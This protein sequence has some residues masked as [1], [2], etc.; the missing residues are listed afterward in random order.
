MLSQFFFSALCLASIALWLKIFINWFSERKPSLQPRLRIQSPIGLVD[1]G[2]MF[3]C[4]LASQVLA[5]GI[6]T[7]VMF[8]PD[9]PPTELTGEQEVRLMITAACSQLIWTFVGLWIIGL[10]YGHAPRIFGWQPEYVRADLKIGVLAFILV[11]PVIMII[12][13]LLTQLVDYSH[14]TLSLVEDDPTIFVIAVAWFMAVLVAPITEELFFRGILQA[15]LQRQDVHFLQFGAE[16]MLGG[17]THQPKQVISDHPG[18]SRLRWMPIILSAFVFAG[19]H[20]GQGPAP[21]PLFVFG[22]AL[23]YVYRQTGSI[24]GCIVMHMLLNGISMFL[25][26]LEVLH[27]SG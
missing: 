18:Q 4:W 12:Q 2:I 10:R 14:S 3:A 19:V 6:V 25:F 11:A 13:L 27:Q 23:G 21:I 15:W 5:A 7:L 16:Q 8:F 24:L 26:T 17:W 22:V 20:L 1:V 9:K